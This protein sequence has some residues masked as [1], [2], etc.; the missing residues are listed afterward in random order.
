MLE[1]SRT[2]NSYK[3][4]CVLDSILEGSIRFLSG[5]ALLGS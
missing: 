5:R 1:L 4:Q 3:F 2:D